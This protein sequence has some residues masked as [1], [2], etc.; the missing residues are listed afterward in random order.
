MN[1]KGKRR[2]YLLFNLYLGSL[3]DFNLQFIYMA[4]IF[5]LIIEQI[6]KHLQNYCK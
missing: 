6:Y 4:I 2:F 5:D 1:K 3:K